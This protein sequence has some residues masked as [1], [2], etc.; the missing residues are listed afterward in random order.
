MASDSATGLVFLIG[1]GWDPAAG[2]RHYGALLAA[3]DTARPQ[4]AC[5]VLD[6]GDGTEQFGRWAGALS[7]AGPCDP[8]PVLVPEG[9]TLDV[10]ALA[11]ADA[12]L[13]CGGLTPPTPPRWLLRASRFGRGWPSG[14]GRTPGSPRARRW[15][16]RGPSSADGSPE[17]SR[18]ARRTQRRTW[19][20]SAWWTGWASSRSASTC[21]APSG[22]RCP[23]CC[24]RWRTSRGVR[25]WGWT[26]TLC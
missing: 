4:V 16:R 23:G 13:V 5:V 9:G 19:R 20:R 21:T 18:C 3:C 17:V 10:A 15:P 2:R 12:V 26:R 8:V 7:T 24:R 11:D 6:E 25:A 22:A 14:T 1:G